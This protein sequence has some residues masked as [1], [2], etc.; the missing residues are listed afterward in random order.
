MIMRSKVD[1]PH[2]FGPMIANFSPRSTRSCALLNKTYTE[3]HPS[4]VKIMFSS[5]R[6]M[7]AYWERYL[8]C[9][10]RGADSWRY[11][12]TEH[13]RFYHF[14][15]LEVSKA[16][17]SKMQRLHPGSIIFNS[18]AA[19][20]LALTILFDN[21]LHIKIWQ[22]YYINT[23]VRRLITNREIRLFK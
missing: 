12:N 17:V 8:H 6:R 13:N 3:N 23:F 1:L 7:T 18:I 10:K 4:Q 5:H 21:S 11:V 19:F 2:P 20:Q 16:Q 14:F 15:K 9:G 22:V